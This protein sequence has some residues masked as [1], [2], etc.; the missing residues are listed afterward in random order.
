MPLSMGYTS[1][2]AGFSS[3]FRMRRCLVALAEAD[4]DV[5]AGHGLESPTPSGTSLLSGG[6]RIVEVAPLRGPVVAP[7]LA[8]GQGKGAPDLNP[9]RGR[10]A[11]LEDDLLD[12]RV[13][14]DEIARAKRHR[15]QDARAH[16]CQTTDDA[17]SHAVPSF[18]AGRTVAGRRALTRAG[19]D[20]GSDSEKLSM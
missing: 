18:H 20:S 7:G 19:D 2:A 8:V 1:G 5:L 4:T 17:Q 15:R 10:L 3:A 16:Y 13:D 14:A 6:T 12:N 9:L 11:R